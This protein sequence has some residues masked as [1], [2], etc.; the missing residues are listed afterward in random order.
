MAWKGRLDTGSVLA[1]PEEFVGAALFL[2]LG[3]N[4]VPLTPARHENG[5]FPKR[6][7]NQVIFPA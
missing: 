7:D 4:F 6:R 3:L 5:A 2:W 1:K